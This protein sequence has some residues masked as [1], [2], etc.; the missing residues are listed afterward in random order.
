MTNGM[1]WTVIISLLVLALCLLLA[2][3]EPP[4]DCGRSGVR[5]VVSGTSYSD[6]QPTIVCNNGRT[7]QP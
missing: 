6:N 7:I 3:T 2:L 1:K 4:R 5:Q